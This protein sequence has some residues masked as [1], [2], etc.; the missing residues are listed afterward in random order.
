[1]S[2]ELR[3]PLNS[4]LGF[5]ELLRD[6]ETNALTERQKRYASNIHNSGAHLLQL[7][8]NILDL[9]KIESGKTDLQY[10]SMSHA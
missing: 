9:A 3:T 10:E 6:D 5:S 7:I 1:M 4:I 2:H 8:N